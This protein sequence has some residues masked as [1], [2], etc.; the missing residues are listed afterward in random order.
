MLVCLTID[1]A[2]V[3]TKNNMGHKCADNSGLWLPNEILIKKVKDILAGIPDNGDDPLEYTRKWL[4]GKELN[5]CDL[6]E[7][8]EWE[9]MLEAMAEL[10]VTDAAGHDEI[11][12]R[13]IK[14]M[15]YALA[16]VMCHLINR[17]FEHNKMPL[18]W[19][20]AKIS[21]LFKGGDRFD[22]KQYRP[23]A[24][25]P[26]MSKVIEKIVIK[27]LKKH[28]ERKKLRFPNYID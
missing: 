28:L 22:A 14:H 5:E 24:V 9:E 16:P 13:L 4:E 20:L 6:T 7:D 15:R 8:V 3:Y 23:V 21:P 17:C 25:L 2:P 18:L 1:Y 12:T 27:R 11:T 10:N 26:A 19:K